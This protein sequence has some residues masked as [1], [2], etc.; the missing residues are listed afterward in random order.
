MPGT[1]IEISL[2]MS[3]IT[4]FDK[5]EPFVYEF[6]VGDN[7]KALAGMI[8]KR[9]SIEGDLEVFTGKAEFPNG[10]TGN[11]PL[12]GMEDLEF[13]GNEPGTAPG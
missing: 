12:E 13:G 7:T 9:H 8:R 11:K 10:W 5:G 1:A 4:I 2:K 6:A 3:K